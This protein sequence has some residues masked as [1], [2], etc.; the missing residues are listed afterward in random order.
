[1]DHSEKLQA[2]LAE[3]L[4]NRLGYRGDLHIADYQTIS[5]NIAKVLLAFST[6]LGNPTGDDLR[7]FFLKNFD[8]KLAPRMETAKVH[9][10][11]GA[12]SVVAEKHVLKRQIEDKDQMVQIVANTRYLDSQMNETWEV[13]SGSDGQKF[14]VRVAADNVGDMLAERRKR[15]QV[16]ARNMSIASIMSAGHN[17]IEVGAIVKVMI[18]NQVVSGAEVTQVLA[19]EYKIKTA[20]G[21]FS[22]P[23][24]AILE[25]QQVSAK[26]DAKT[27]KNVEEYFATVFGKDYAERL[28]H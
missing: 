20:T 9:S 12:I 5:A 11:E 7:S 6:N 21:A 24:E 2:R 19:E 13:K 4:N 17:L 15:M 16:Q 14:L 23:K 26:S 28:V 10:S 22:I 18:D 8:G 3:K 25:V 1:M 27:D